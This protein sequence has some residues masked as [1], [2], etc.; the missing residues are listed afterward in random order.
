MAC[1]K[2]EFIGEYNPTERTEICGELFKAT[3]QTVYGKTPLE[4]PRD[5][6][7]LLPSI[8]DPNGAVSDA[9]VEAH[10][11]VERKE[12]PGHFGYQKKIDK[13]T[14]LITRMVM[15]SDVADILTYIVKED[16]TEKEVGGLAVWG[17]TVKHS[18]WVFEGSGQ[19]VM[20]WDEAR[21]MHVPNLAKRRKA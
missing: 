7:S 2:V 3:A 19:K 5:M 17:Q 11:F 13:M 12:M 16:D 9:L 6:I 15:G 20:V 4:S 1:L 10:L 14:D 18:G 8:V 21:H